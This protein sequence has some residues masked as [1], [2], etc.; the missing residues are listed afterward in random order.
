MPVCSLSDLP[1]GHYEQYSAGDQVESCSD[2]GIEAELWNCEVRA[3]KKAAILSD[4]CCSEPSLKLLY[5]TPE[6]LQQEGLRSALQ[7]A[8]ESHLLVSFAIDEAHC[9][10]QWGHDFRWDVLASCSIPH[11]MSACQP[12]FLNHQFVPVSEL[13]TL[14]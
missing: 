7:T 2:L 8:A 13:S 5:A 1:A 14:R 11:V 4:I 10:T 3:E 9:V 12:P 6:A